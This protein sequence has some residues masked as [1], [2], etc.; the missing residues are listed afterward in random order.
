LRRGSPEPA[1]TDS[2]SRSALA[3]ALGAILAGALSVGATVAT[4]ADFAPDADR[5]ALVA[6]AQPIALSV[7]PARARPD[8]DGLVWPARGEVTGRFG[9]HRGGHE[10]AGIDIPLPTGTPIRAAADGKVVMRQ[11]EAGYGK[12]TCIAHARFSTCYAHQS[13]FRVRDRAT[14]E[15]GEVIGYV[16]DTGTSST[17]HLHFEVRSGRRPWGT[18]RDPAKYLPRR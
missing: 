5:A 2:R 8:S 11:E 9:E 13:R 4:G 17:P 3:L 6:R 14:V 15:Q 10:H 7:S 12:Y 1:K 18:P 16:G